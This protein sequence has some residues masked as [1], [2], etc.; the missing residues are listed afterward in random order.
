MTEPDK[1]VWNSLE[2]AKLVVPAVMTFLVAAVG[3]KISVDLEESRNQTA[4]AQHYQNAVIEK[5]MELYD[6]I[7]RDVNTLFSY[8]F[9]VGKWKEFTPDDI[10]KKLRD[11]D[12]V[13]FSYQP[14]FSRSFF[15]S[16]THREED[17]GLREEMFKTPGEWGADTKLRT[18]KAYRAEYAKRWDGDWRQRLTDEDNREHICMK[19]GNF[20]KA[21]AAELRVSRL[22]DQQP[23][24][25]SCPV[26]RILR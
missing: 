19:Y 3:Y 22:T 8:Y 12:A 4:E 24:L 18:T 7:A 15:E 13:M 2:I 9:Y 11:M 17:T 6:L 26:C 10:L 21:L 23:I 14:I 25:V 20:M 1:S 16:Y 5:R